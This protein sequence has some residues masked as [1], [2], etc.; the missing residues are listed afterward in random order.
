[1]F[2]T[3]NF[4][5]GL[6]KIPS[7]AGRTVSSTVKMSSP[8]QQTV[9]LQSPG[10]SPVTPINLSSGMLTSKT[11]GKMLF[12]FQHQVHFYFLFTHLFPLCF[13]H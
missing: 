10:L 4:V 3:N 5:S 13:N 6:A 12:I 9:Q 2:H 11:Q 8:L 1:M 7:R